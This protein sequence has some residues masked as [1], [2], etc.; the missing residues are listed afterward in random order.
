MFLQKKQQSWENVRLYIQILQ[1]LGFH[2]SAWSAR[3]QKN[4][5]MDVLQQA[6]TASVGI[7]AGKREGGQFSQDFL[8]VVESQIETF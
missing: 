4:V 1:L 7:P 5:S 2:K 3:I 6:D 8:D